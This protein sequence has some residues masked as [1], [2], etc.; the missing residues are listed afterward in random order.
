MKLATERDNMK[1]IL[2]RRLGDWPQVQLLARSLLDTNIDSWDSYMQYFDSLFSGASSVAT[3]EMEAREFVAQQ[4]ERNGEN[5]RGP[6]LAELEL[7]KRIGKSEIFLDR[8]VGY[9]QRF[10]AK[11]CCFADMRPY[12]ALVSESVS[13]TDRFMELLKAQLADSDPVK[14]RLPY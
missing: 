4:L 12:L 2:Y 9:Y 3:A 1:I 13:E 14:V 10:G 11:L 7:E 5:K 6:W 8:L